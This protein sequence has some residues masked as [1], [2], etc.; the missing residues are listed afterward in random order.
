MWHTV[1]T[2]ILGEL[3]IINANLHEINMMIWGSLNA[4]SVK[5]T[6]GTC[7]STLTRKSLENPFIA[8]EA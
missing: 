4:A 7:I 2:Q 3:Q 8:T 6:K 1:Q 5:E